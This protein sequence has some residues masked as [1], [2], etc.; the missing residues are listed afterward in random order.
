MILDLSFSKGKT[1]I[2]EEGRQLVFF[3]IYI[4][5]SRIYALLT[6]DNS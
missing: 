6:T 5:F 3:F 4:L 2:E 1:T